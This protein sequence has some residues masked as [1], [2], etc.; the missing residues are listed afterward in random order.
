[1]GHVRKILAL[2]KIQSIPTFYSD[3]LSIELTE[4]FHI[5]IRNIR[6]EFDEVEFEKIAQTF[7]GALQRWNEL[8]RPTKKEKS[9]RG[10]HYHN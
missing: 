6:M 7:C 9:G 4:D 8:D 2:K 10:G 5:H 3:H 1:M